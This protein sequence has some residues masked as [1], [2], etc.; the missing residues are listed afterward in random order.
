MYN[1]KSY[2]K[3]LLRGMVQIFNHYQILNKNSNCKIYNT[4]KDSLLDIFDF[5]NFKKIV[6]D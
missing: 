1:Y 6:E 4:S 2:N 5:R 3:I